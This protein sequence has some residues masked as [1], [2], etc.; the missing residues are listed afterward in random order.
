MSSFT[1]PLS[2]ITSALDPPVPVELRKEASPYAGDKGNLKFPLD[3]PIPYSLISR[4]V[5][6][7]VKEHERKGKVRGNKGESAAQPV[8]AADVQAG[9]T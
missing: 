9:R 2:R 7:R 5:E 3:K 4:I 8:V 1:S 6:A